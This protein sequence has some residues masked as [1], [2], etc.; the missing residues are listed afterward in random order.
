MVALI[1]FF[2]GLFYGL[3]DIID[4]DDIFHPL[5]K[6]DSRPFEQ[7]Q[8]SLRYNAQPVLINDA[9]YIPGSDS[10]NHA[11]IWKYSLSRR[12]WSPI[13]PPQEITDS[14]FTVTEYQSQLLLIGKKYNQKGMLIIM[15]KFD[16]DKGWLPIEDV[17]TPPIDSMQSASDFSAVSEGRCLIVSWVKDE[18]F[19]L[20]IFDGLT[21]KE[22]DGPKCCDGYRR[23]N[24]IVHERILYLSD[25]RHDSIYSVPLE[26]L[27]CDGS[28]TWDRLPDLPYKHKLHE[29]AANLTLLNF[30]ILATLIPSFTKD[31]SLVLALEP[32]TKSWIDLGEISC[33]VGH[34][35]SPRLVGLPPGSAGNTKLIAM[36]QIVR[37][38][39]GVPVGGQVL[40]PY[41]ALQRHFAVLEISATGMYFYSYSLTI[42]RRMREGLQ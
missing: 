16:E 22:V 1:L 4:F 30:S 10:N 20:L 21:W 11:V 35:T 39:R 29:G 14:N 31:T 9:V 2:T 33:E 26:S 5:L 8:R 37:V 17:T 15:N 36:G 18:Q 24:M 7:E 40:I 23:P 19:Q 41:T 27:L 3:Q 12:S 25:C 32:R 13:P 38:E 42:A 34:T 6:L 28:E